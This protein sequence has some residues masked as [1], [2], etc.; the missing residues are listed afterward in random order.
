MKIKINVVWFKRDLRVTD[1]GPLRAASERGLPVIPLYIVEPN[2]W[3]EETASRRH[4]CFIHDCL[5]ELREE[6]SLIGQP[7]VVRVGETVEEFESLENI[8]D[9]Q[10]I[11]CHEE[12]GTA[13]S[14][15]R[16]QEFSAWCKRKSIPILFFPSNGVV[17]GLKNRDNWASIHNGRMNAPVV[18]APNY[19]QPL[20]DLKIGRIP[21]KTDSLFGTQVPGVT[22]PGGRKQGLNNISE[23]VGS[24]I[25]HYLLNISTPNSSAR[26]CSRLSPHLTWG[27]FSVREVLQAL[28]CG[29]VFDKV[30]S[31]RNMARSVSAFRSRLS[32]RCHFIQKLED[33]PTIETHCMH[34]FFEQMRSLEIDKFAFDSWKVGQTGYPLIDAC[35]RSLIYEGWITFRMRAMLV[36]FAAYN[37]WLD[38]RVIGTYLAGLFTDFEPGI[39][40]SQLQMQSGVTGINA[41]RIYNPV[42]Q[43]E[44]LD[45]NGQFIKKWVPE[46]K[47]ISKTWIHQPWE[48]PVELQKK[49]SCSI[50]RDYPLPL[51]DHKK[52]VKIAWD[53]IRS[54]RRQDGFDQK[55]TEV[56][57]KLASRNRPISYKKQISKDPLQ[58]E[59]TF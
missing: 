41:I 15:R 56:F 54:I 49:Y 42:K 58:L 29:K 57:E 45:P 6:C 43:S 38:W 59:L 10:T 51:V 50:G 4:W 1:H 36:S 30:T 8:F 18:A 35:M 52:A 14:F 23:F 37:L 44:E 53:K 12:T 46:L 5:V 31:N 17:R 22:Q 55:A 13:W 2:Y 33:Q 48:M 24:R 3:A 7:L 9:I 21:N 27:T 20:S 28:K 26:F 47:D 40:Y 39:H 19:L 11:F 25:E 34:G 16:D 32:W